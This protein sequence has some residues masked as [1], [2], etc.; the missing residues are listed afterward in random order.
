MRRCPECF[1][2]Y[3]GSEKFCDNDGSPLV[4]IAVLPASAPHDSRSN[5]TWA[6]ATLGVVVGVFLSLIIGGFV[7]TMLR[8]DR[9]QPREMDERPAA[10]QRSAP[11]RPAQLAST[12]LPEATPAPAV[13]PTP[14]AEEEVAEQAAPAPATAPETTTKPAP[15]LL[16]T[17][18]VST[19][20]GSPDD[21][22]GQTI[23]RLKNGTQIEVDAAW[24]EGQGIWYKRGA[25]VT[26]VERSRVEDIT[27]KAQPEAAPSPAAP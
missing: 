27:A 26:F 16:N 21:K 13:S 25:L 11:A 2:S 6:I 1:E 18:P 10:T 22:G 7:Y 8:D 9:A 14:E 17:G 5:E 12:L 3:G 19:N 4:E 23:V 15:A 20:A 24:E